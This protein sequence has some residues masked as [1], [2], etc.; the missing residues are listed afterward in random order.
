MTKGPDSSLVL[1]IFSFS[2][3]C[4]TPRDETEHGGGFVF[5]CRCLPNPGR[6]ERFFEKTGQDPEVKSYLEA[7][8][9]VEQ[10]YSAAAS[11]VHQA[12]SNYK[13]REFNHL[14][15]AF[16]C[17]GGQHRSVYMAERLADDLR[18]QGVQVFLCHTCC[19]RWPGMLKTKSV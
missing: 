2:Y 5:D 12:V 13:E 16:G 1:R 10:F 15:V 3:P 18:N 14:M 19:E 8:P 4:G 17:T 7:H 9:L 6:E 11:L